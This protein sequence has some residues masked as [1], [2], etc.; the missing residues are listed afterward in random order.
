MGPRP[1]ERE[2]PHGAVFGFVA[3]E[4]SEGGATGDKAG[5]VTKI[6][7]AR[8]RCLELMKWQAR[9]CPAGEEVLG[10]TRARWRI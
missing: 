1:Q 2:S 10:T 9:H 8:V 3:A 5:E 4:K 7:V 6:H